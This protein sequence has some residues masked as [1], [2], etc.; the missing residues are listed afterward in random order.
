MP[1]TSRPEAHNPK[2]VPSQARERGWLARDRS[3][4]IAL[5]ATAI[6]AA[7]AAQHAGLFQPSRF[8]YFNYLANSFLKG[9]LSLVEL[10]PSKLDL[11]PF[12][13]NF[14]L[15]YP[16]FPAV[17]LMP[18]VRV[19]G[20]GFSDVL[21]TI[22]LGGLNVWL[23]G[24]LLRSAVARGIV[25]LSHRQVNLLSLTFA[26]GSVHLPLAAHG[27]VWYTAQL[28]GFACVVAAFIAALRLEGS[29]AFLAVGLAIGC[30]IMTRN[31]LIFQG[32][33]PLAM[34]LDRNQLLPGRLAPEAGRRS[35]VL[36]CLAAAAIPIVFAIALLA[37][38]NFAR[39]GNPLDLGIAYHQMDPDFRAN[40]ERYGAFS[41]HYLPANFFYQFLAYPFPLRP[42]SLMG[43]S[44][45]LL[46]P[47]F[48]ASFWASSSRRDRW[49]AWVLAASIALTAVP[50]LLLMGTGWTQFGP[51]YTLDFTA[52]LL[53]L[54]AIGLRRWPT[55]LVAIL[56]VISILH[57]LSGALYL[58]TRIV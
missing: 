18:F 12:G 37:Y 44:L 46:T 35:R 38:Y 15:F 52:P 14:Y 19:F 26:L 58:G 11:S 1:R 54:T 32:L 41:L 22:A 24:V 47:V 3:L 23:V 28:I 7:V 51:R 10:P 39:F 16:P 4:V 43:G 30:A 21:F 27:R 5:V 49:S 17:I 57:Y 45:F 36:A 29:R 55:W 53:L 25:E 48:L 2:R 42:S 34:L 40:Y 13:G 33:W 20:I 50:I 9:H 8:A 31:H 6:Y 56:T